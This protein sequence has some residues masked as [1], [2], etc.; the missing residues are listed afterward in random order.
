MKGWIVAINW[1]LSFIGLSVD[2]ERTPLWVVM[3]LFGWFLAST[4]LLKFAD[5]QGWMKGVVKR[6]KMDEL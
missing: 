3:A 2:T 5:W 6:F 1:V 4:L